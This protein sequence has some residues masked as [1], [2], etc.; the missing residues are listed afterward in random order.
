MA[1][2]GGVARGEAGVARG[3][4][5]VARGE[6]GV[7]GLCTTAIGPEVA[8]AVGWEMIG[9]D[10]TGDG[11]ADGAGDG[12]TDGAGVCASPGAPEAR[13]ATGVWF[14]P[15]AVAAGVGLAATGTVGFDVAT[16]VP[17]VGAAPMSGVGTGADSVTPSATVASTRLTMPRASTRRT[18]CIPLTWILGSPKATGGRRPTA[19]SRGW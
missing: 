8:T 3:E 15:G 18:R 5:G 17:E 11:C 10:G 2:G 1:C 6:A 7:A 14:T 16:A 12:A 19:P 13:G 9:A 4:A